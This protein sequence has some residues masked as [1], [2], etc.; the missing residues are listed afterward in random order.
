MDRWI[1]IT[2]AWYWDT[3]WSAR[4]LRLEKH[5]FGSHK[6]FLVHIISLFFLPLYYTQT[7]CMTAKRCVFQVVGVPRRSNR[8]SV[9]RLT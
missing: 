3:I 1:R 6:D 2:Q 5:M 9:Q 7:I 8:I 4:G